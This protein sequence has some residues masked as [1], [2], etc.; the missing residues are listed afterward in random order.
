MRN[1]ERGKEEG[2]KGEGVILKKAYEN[3]ASE[4]EM[5]GTA[6]KMRENGRNGERNKGWGKK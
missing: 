2:R 4:M 6:E 3:R 1:E 5:R